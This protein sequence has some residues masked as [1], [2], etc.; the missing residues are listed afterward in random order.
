MKFT[1]QQI[2]LLIKTR[3]EIRDLSDRQ[4]KLYDN[5]AKELNVTVYAEDW[6]FDYIYNEYGSI[7]DIENRMN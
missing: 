7:E 6:L 3:D 5:L 4:H 2:E 1:P